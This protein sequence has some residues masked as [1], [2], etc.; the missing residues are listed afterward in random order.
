M[1]DAFEQNLKQTLLEK[2]TDRKFESEDDMIATCKRVL[3]EA[4]YIVEKKMELKDTNRPDYSVYHDDKVS[5]TGRTYMIKSRDGVYAQR[6]V[7]H[8]EFMRESE[9][10]NPSNY[11]AIIAKDLFHECSN[12]ILTDHVIHSYER[13]YAEDAHIFKI[14]VPVRTI[15]DEEKR[16][17]DK[18]FEYFV[19]NTKRYT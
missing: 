5:N 10:L 7:D 8:Y 3:V 9:A 6:S 15:S 2:A 16:G 12:R 17:N 4:G 19:Q 18:T 13:R 1:I 14:Q 11:A